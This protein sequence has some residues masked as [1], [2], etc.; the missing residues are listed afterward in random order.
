[1]FCISDTDAIIINIIALFCLL[2]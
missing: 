1:M 2:H